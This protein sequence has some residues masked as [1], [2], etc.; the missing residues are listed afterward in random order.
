MDVSTA[1]FRFRVSRT[2]KEVSPLVSKTRPSSTKYKD[3][4]AVEMFREWQRTR[5]LKSPISMLKT[6][7]KIVVFIS[8]VLSRA[9]WRTWMLYNYRGVRDGAVMRA[10]ASH[11]C[12]SN[13]GGDAICGLS[14][15]LV[16]SFALRGFSPGL[17][18]SPLLKNQLFQIPIRPGI[19]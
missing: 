3:K 1:N 14:L 15:L 17:R 9:I 16:L 8:R 11:Q 10:L 18:F 2:V 7:S 5:T 6:F 12:G 4:W 13:P 19:R